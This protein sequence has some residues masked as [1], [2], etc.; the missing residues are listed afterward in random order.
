LGRR[1]RA[2]E[3]KLGSPDIE[4]WFQSN[5]SSPLLSLAY[6]RFFRAELL[7]DPVACRS[8]RLVWLI[9]Q[10]SPYELIY[11][12]P[13]HLRRAQIFERQGDRTAF[14]AEHEQVRIR[15]ERADVEL[16][17]ERPNGGIL[18]G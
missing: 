2:P 1:I 4:L 14:L 16:L 9:A 10:R 3:L 6:E 15:W 7:H 8:A 17:G 13:A 12:A 5:V 18:V 11:A